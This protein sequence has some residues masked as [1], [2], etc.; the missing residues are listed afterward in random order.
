[1]SITILVSI[2]EVVVSNRIIVTKTEKVDA[3]AGSIFE[4]GLLQS[5]VISDSRAY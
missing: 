5:I 1:M 3:L 4:L 2:D